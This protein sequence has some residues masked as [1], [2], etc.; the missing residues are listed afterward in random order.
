MSKKENAP[1]YS[2]PNKL[3]A[4]V[5]NVDVLE[6]NVERLDDKLFHLQNKINAT[7]AVSR[8]GINESP[9]FQSLLA[10]KER[11]EE[12]RAVEKE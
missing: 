8:E 3:M 1:I 7:V 5:E 4:F 2:K 12:Q 6:R 10:K 11:L 9:Q